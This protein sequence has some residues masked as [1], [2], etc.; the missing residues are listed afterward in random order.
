MFGQN[1]AETRMSGGGQITE[2]FDALR[3]SGA[4]VVIVDPRRTDSVSAFNA[5]WLPIN[6]GTDAAF[7]CSDGTYHADRRVDR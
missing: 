3:Q 2:T 4:K 1:I 7:G 5:T 6:P